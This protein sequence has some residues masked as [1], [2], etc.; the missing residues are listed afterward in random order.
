MKVPDVRIEA[1]LR[2]NLLY[3]AIF[4][5]WRSVLAFCK[6]RGHCSTFVGCMLNLSRSPL[7]KNSGS[8]RPRAIRLAEDLGFSPQ[9][10]FPPHLYNI[11][12]SKAAVEVS[13]DE[14]ESLHGGYVPLLMPQKKVEDEVVKRELQMV[15]EDVLRTLTP[16]EEQVIRL[17]FGV[18]VGNPQTLHEISSVLDLHVERVRQT[19]ARALRKLRHPDRSKKLSQCLE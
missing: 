8:Y 15:A 7:I 1:R 19:E 3:H 4:D 9:D 10:L 12:T 13:F 17:H 11:K 18:G 16:L 5:V 2:N 6:E 14:M